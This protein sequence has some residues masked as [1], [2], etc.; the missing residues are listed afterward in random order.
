MNSLPL[1]IQQKIFDLT[2][3]TKICWHY[4]KLIYPIFEPYFEEMI[5]VL[6]GRCEDKK[7]TILIEVCTDQAPRKVSNMIAKELERKLGSKFIPYMFGGGWS[8]KK[9]T[10]WDIKF[11]SVKKLKKCQCRFKIEHGKNSGV[12][13]GFTDDTSRTYFKIDNE[14]IVKITKEEFDSIST[15]QNYYPHDIQRI[16]SKLH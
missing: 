16:F 10:L 5:N 12:L 7:L 1:E 2:I 4:L 15:D 14:E 9:G 3:P 6:V 13:C 11:I 8:D